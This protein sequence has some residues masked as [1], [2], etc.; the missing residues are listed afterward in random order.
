M[1]EG[2]YTN[3]GKLIRNITDTIYSLKGTFFAKEKKYRFEKEVDLRTP[4]YNIYSDVLNYFTESG[5][6]YFYGPTDIITDDS[7]IYCEI[8]FYDTENDNG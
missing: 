2:F 5:K 4:K 8:G 7:K 1:Q 3:K 6:S